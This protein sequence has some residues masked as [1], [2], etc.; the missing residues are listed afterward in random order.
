V[1]LSSGGALI[2][3][4]EAIDRRYVPCGLCRPNVTLAAR[5]G[6][7]RRPTRRWPFGRRGW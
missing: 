6:L 2:S 1:L 7:S 5:L 4:G 3:I